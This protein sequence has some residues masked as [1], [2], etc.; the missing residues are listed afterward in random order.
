MCI[1]R[2]ETEEEAE[3]S[4]GEDVVIGIEGLMGSSCPTHQSQRSQPTKVAIEPQPTME[5]GETPF[6]R[7]PTKQTTK[8]MTEQTCWTMTVESATKG[9]KS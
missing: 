2:F 8:I 4:S 9:Q 6:S 3:A 1:W 5:T 7:M